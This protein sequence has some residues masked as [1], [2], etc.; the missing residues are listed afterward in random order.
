MGDATIFA[1]QGCILQG[2]SAE[3]TKLPNV[4]DASAG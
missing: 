2:Q 1:H 3:E 4:G